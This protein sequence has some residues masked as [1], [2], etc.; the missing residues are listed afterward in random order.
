M[1]NIKTTTLAVALVATMTFNGCVNSGLIVDDSFLRTKVG[2]GIGAVTGGILAYQ[3][4]KGK[5]GSRKRRDALVGMLGGAVLGGG[6]GY[7]L[8]VQANKVANALG[9]GVNNDPLAKID[10]N[11]TL[12]VSKADNYVKIM[13]R[14]P[15]MFATG[16]SKLS[17][18]TKNNIN[19]VAT[20][21]QEYPKTIVVIAGHTDNTGKA[22]TNERLSVERA[23]SI[24]N[25]LETSSIVNKLLISGCSFKAPIVENSSKT[26][27]ALN[28]RVELFLYN[29]ADKITSACD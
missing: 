19:K 9:T 6:A 26:N 22:S 25:I 17:S 15:R 5:K 2:T 1:T 3:K 10:P 18:Y 8:D 21:L 23:R 7:A 27:R 16:S 24:A 20:L 12:I 29:Q 13:F 4:A 11:N 28:R 14:D